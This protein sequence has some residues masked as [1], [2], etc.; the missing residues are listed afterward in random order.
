M[1]TFGEYAEAGGLMSYG[2]NLADQYLRVATYVGK[3]LTQQSPI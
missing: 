1:G 2:A 3:I